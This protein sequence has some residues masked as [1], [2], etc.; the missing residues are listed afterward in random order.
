[1][2]EIARK[3]LESTSLNKAKAALEQGLELLASRQKLI[4]IVDRSESTRKVASSSVTM[5]R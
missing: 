4:K 3:P 2:E 1:M 5:A